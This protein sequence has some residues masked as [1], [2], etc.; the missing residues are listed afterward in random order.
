M[1]N[2]LEK[3]EKVIQSVFDWFWE[4]LLKS[5][6]DKCH[7][8]ASSKVLVGIQISNIKV[9]NESRVNLLGIHINNRLNFD[10]VSLLCKKANKIIGFLNI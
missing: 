2:I 9:T 4:N 7:L 5:N 8:V 1:I 3:L 6:T 10:Y